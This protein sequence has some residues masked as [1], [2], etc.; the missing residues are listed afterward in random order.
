MKTGKHTMLGGIFILLI[1]LA[2]CQN[3]F[4]AQPAVNPKQITI[5]DASGA[6]VAIPAQIKRIGDAWPAHNEVVCM[7]G[8]GDKIVATTTAAAQRPWMKVVNPQMS[9]AVTAFDTT[10]VNLETLMAAKPDIVFTP[11]NNK[12]AQKIAD[13]KIPVVQLMFNDFD[14]LKEC[15]R[16]TGVILGEEA[17]QRAEKYIAYLDY[18]LNRI[19]GI[20]AGIPREQKPKV[21]HITRLAPLMVDGRDTIINAWI[22]VAGGINAAETGGEVSMEQLITW[23]PDVIIFGNTALALNGVE[24]G[25]RALN[26]TLQDEKW[27]RLKAVQTGKVYINPEGAFFWDRYGAEEALQIQWAAKILHPDKFQDIDIVQETRFFYRTFLNYDLSAEE[28]NR[29]ING[30]PPAR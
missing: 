27:R 10:G 7:L 16:L 4:K 5:T 25:A 24:D 8:A 13:L 23:N 14:S 28:A 21:I 30:K 17:K 22:T 3:A 12:S 20:T 18:N 11:L 2:G 29:I 15:F 1:F 6:K 19:T 26:G 9:Q